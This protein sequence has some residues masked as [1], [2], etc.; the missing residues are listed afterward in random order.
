[1]TPEIQV[2][3]LRALQQG[4]ITRVGDDKTEIVDVRVIAATHRNL[5]KMV[6]DGDFREDLF[7]RLAIGVIELPA[8]RDRSEDIEPLILDLSQELNQG[9]QQYSGYK[10]KKISDK[11]IKFI[12]SQPWLG[13]IRE[14]WNTMNRAFLLSDSE[15]ITD[16]DLHDS[17][18]VRNKSEDE[19]PVHLALGQIVDVNQLT[20]KYQK[21]YIVAALK[22]SGNVRKTAAEMLSLGNHQNLKN[23]MERLGMLSSK[24]SD[25]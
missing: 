8:L 9:A 6:E 10:S 21:K 16:K 4:E 22:A 18:L 7:Y 17:M 20:D 15:V 3:L 5:M 19:Q 25:E 24:K 23:W 1:L 12:L 14:L 11:G 13:N 2:K